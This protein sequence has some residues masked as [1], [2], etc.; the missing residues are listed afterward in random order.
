MA[1]TNAIF[2]TLDYAHRSKFAYKK[3]DTFIGEGCTL[4]DRD[5]VRTIIFQDRAIFYGKSRV[6]LLRY[7]K[8]ITKKFRYPFILSENSYDRCFLR[9]TFYFK[10]LVQPTAKA[11]GPIWQATLKDKG[12]EKRKGISGNI[13]FSSAAKVSA[14]P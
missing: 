12:S 10:I 5:S 9:T 11:P 4:S 13:S 3:Q 7:K 6:A 8:R 2:K 14:S 1:N